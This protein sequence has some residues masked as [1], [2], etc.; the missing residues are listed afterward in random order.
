MRNLLLFGLLSISILS[1]KDDKTT[2]EIDDELIRDYLAKTN[3]AA[4]K[5]SSGLYYFIVKEGNGEFPTYSSNINVK[6][7]GY[8]LDSTVFQK[9]INDIEGPLESFILGWRYGIP[10]LSEGGSGKLFIPRH[11][12]YKTEVLVFDIELK[13][14]F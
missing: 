9:D 3:I 4:T 12:G 5:H 10:L 11:L 7:L 14:V 2:Y 13:E 6:T 8:Y 1:C